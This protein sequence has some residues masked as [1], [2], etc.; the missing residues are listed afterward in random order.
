MGGRSFESGR[1]WD[2]GTGRGDDARRRSE[3]LA[4]RAPDLRMCELFTDLGESALLPTEEHLHAGAAQRCCGLEAGG[5]A[6]P[7]EDDGV[8]EAARM[9]IENVACTLAESATRA[10]GEGVKVDGRMNPWLE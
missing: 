6:A 2:G 5:D 8:P 1:Q 7:E 10:G 9:A 3:Q 4:I